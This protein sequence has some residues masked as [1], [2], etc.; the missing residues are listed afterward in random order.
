MTCPPNLH[1]SDPKSTRLYSYTQTKRPLPPIDNYSP[2]YP[3]P[4]YGFDPYWD[5]HHYNKHDLCFY[6]TFD[7]HN[8]EI[9]PAS[10]DLDDTL[11]CA[12]NNALV[13]PG[14]AKRT[15][16]H[17]TAQNDPQ[18]KNRNPEDHFSHADHQSNRLDKCPEGQSNRMDH[19][20]DR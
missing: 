7:K 1:S 3:D 17:L 18:D 4:E 11:N 10:H 19:R 13:D 2:Y 9:E 5:V 16:V 14:Q 15:S 12:L 6:Q 20:S 8:N